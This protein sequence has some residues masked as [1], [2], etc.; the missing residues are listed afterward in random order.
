MGLYNVKHIAGKN[1]PLDIFMKEDKDIRYFMAVRNS[2]MCDFENSYERTPVKENETKENEVDT[3]A[4][5][6]DPAASKEVP[7]G[8]QQESRENGGCQ[9]GIPPPSNAFHFNNNKEQSNI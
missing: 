2:I 7:K 4:K 1:N 9:V 6:S 5:A 8:A 3:V